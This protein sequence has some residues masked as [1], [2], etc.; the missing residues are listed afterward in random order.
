MPHRRRLPSALWPRIDQ[1][2]LK[3]ALA[4]EG[5]FRRGPAAHWADSTRQAIEDANGN[6][7]GYLAMSDPAAL[8]EHPLDRLTEDRLTAYV[9]HLAET[10]GAAGRCIYLDHLQ[11]ALRV[12]FPGQAPEMLNTVVA[13]L[14][15][16]YEPK[17]KPWVTTPRLTG[18]GREMI[19]K[20]LRG[21][22]RYRNILY[23]DGLMLVLWPPRP[24]RRR[25]FAQMRIGRHLQKLGDEWRLMFDGSEMKSGRPFQM[26]VPRE[27]VPFLER[28]LRE[29]RP[30]FPRAD[31][32]DALWIGRNGRPLSMN[33][34]TRLV[35]ERT[36]T[37]LGCRISP[38]G[39]RRCAASTIAV[40]APDKIHVAPALLD[41]STLRTTA[42]HYIMARGVEASREYAKV[43]DDL[44]PKRTRRQR[45]RNNRRINARQLST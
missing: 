7:V 25:A 14:K 20:A 44:M 35:G 40:F 41:H 37:G 24:V 2:A 18:L 39:F 22:A 45:V 6:W 16:E 30:M 12:M 15:H 29:V 32:F 8:A 17:P 4:T 33:S 38:H 27:A 26:T 34:I 31:E 42:K 9:D 5:R 13:Q 21:N 10:V 36:E 28:Y 11:R 3:S 43:I 19:E 23:R 1:I